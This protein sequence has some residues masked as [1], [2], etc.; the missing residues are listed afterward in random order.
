MSKRIK[1]LLLEDIK[2]LGQ[3]GEIV[4]VNEGYARNFLFPQ[5]K[6]ALATDD[7]IINYQKKG[8]EEQIVQQKEFEDIKK[9]AELLAD[10]ELTISARVKKDDSI[11]G[12]ITSSQIAKELTEKT[13]YKFKAGNIVIDKPVTALGTYDAT[14]KLSS[15]IETPIK[16]TVTAE[17]NGS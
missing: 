1:V 5:E 14:I 15:D 4:T 7:T 10:T 6:A 2:S 11:Y 3:T 17:K 9:R 12:K 13:P 8:K 16:V